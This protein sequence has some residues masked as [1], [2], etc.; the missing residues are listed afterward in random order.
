MLLSQSIE[1]M[2]REFGMPLDDSFYSQSVTNFKD[3]FL[4]IFSDAVILEEEHRNFEFMGSFKLVY[5]YVPLSYNII[6]EN[7][8][9]TFT[10]IIEDNKA[11]ANLYHIKKFDNHLCEKNM[12]DSLTI[13]KHVLLENRFD[14]YIWKSGKL[15]KKNEEGLKRIKDINKHLKETLDK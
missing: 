1:K 4:E 3:A 14:F 8:L 5:L 15:Y 2:G 12:I 7:E 9:R 13:L 6:V 10:I 11:T